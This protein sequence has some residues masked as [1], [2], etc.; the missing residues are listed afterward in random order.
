MIPAAQGATV[1]LVTLLH[2]QPLSPG[3]V[4][5]S[6]AVG[7]AVARVTTVA[8]DSEGGLAVSAADEQWARELYRVEDGRAAAEPAERP[9]VR[10]AGIR[11]GAPIAAMPCGAFRAE[12]R[13]LKPSPLAVYFRTNLVGTPET[14]KSD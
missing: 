1:A 14:L 6:A 12:A 3:E 7:G 10:P 4:A 8:L 13:G 9:G 2:D 11:A 5:W